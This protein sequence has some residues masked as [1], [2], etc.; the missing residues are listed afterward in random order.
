MYCASD[1]FACFAAFLIVSSS[2]GYMRVMGRMAVCARPFVRGFTLRC[3]LTLRLHAMR[4]SPGFRNASKLPT[5]YI[6]FGLAS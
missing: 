5:K 4:L 3:Y 6:Y 1:L 2:S